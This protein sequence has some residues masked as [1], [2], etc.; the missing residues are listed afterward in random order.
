MTDESSSDT[1]IEDELRRQFHIFDANGSGFIEKEE[2]K[3][4]LNTLG[5]Q[6]S[7]EGFNHLLAV[8]GS[9]DDRLNFREFIVWNRELFKEEMKA[10]FEAIDMDGS[11]Y[12]NKSELTEYSS[13]MKYGLTEEQIEEFLYQADA[14]DNDKVGLDEYISAVVSP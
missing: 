6:I 4:G 13:R 11:G 10:E 3:V 2:L 7:D 9:T 12:I 8:V 5:F 14:N 1:Q